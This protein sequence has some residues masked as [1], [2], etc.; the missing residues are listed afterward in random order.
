[1]PGRLAAVGFGWFLLITIA[2]YTANLASI[3]VASQQAVNYITSIDDAIAQQKQIC[4][5]VAL[6][7]DLKASFPGAKLEVMGSSNS[8]V[9]GLRKGD[10]EVALIQKS[11]IEEAMAGVSNE[12][13]CE[14]T[15]SGA[16]CVRDANNKP[17]T[18]EF[19]QK[20]L[21]VGAKVA[22]I[23]VSIPVA[24]MLSKSFSYTF[25]QMQE[26][27]EVIAIKNA[28]AKRLEGKLATGC[29]A[30]VNQAVSSQ[31]TL[32]SMQ[33]TFYIAMFVQVIALI[34]GLCEFCTQRT[35]QDW[36]G[37]YS[38]HLNKPPPEHDHDKSHVLTRIEFEAQMAELRSLLVAQGRAT[39][40][41]VGYYDAATS[42]AQNGW[43]HGW[44]ESGEA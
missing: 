37:L 1:V 11:K 9:R 2:S 24:K 33:G 27:G 5:H 7:P 35:I 34:L 42:F 23:P 15:S 8:V 26:S 40:V 38:H 28:E 6:V 20:F 13:D 22:S 18:A 21:S 4:V 39:H 31:L 17:D 19:C 36:L 16:V 10:C 25:Q 30:S 43:A 29:D 12:Q 32:S 44:V 3:L 14:S 41:P